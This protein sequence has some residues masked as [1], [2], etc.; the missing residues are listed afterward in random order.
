VV[1]D[2]VGT[3]SRL[4]D[5]LEGVEPTHVDVRVVSH[6]HEDAYSLTAVSDWMGDEL[7][8]KRR[9]DGIFSAPDERAQS[10]GN[11]YLS[12]FRV[13]TV[14]GE[15]TPFVLTWA[16]EDGKWRILS[17]KLESP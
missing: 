15:T 7:D 8:C 3:V 14:A 1:A 11:Y 2:Y 6:P 13:K 17:Y 4:E 12:A 9:V 10:F 16:K 5:A